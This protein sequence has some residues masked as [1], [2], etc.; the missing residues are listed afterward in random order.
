[1]SSCLE[2]TTHSL[3]HQFGGEPRRGV[4][5]KHSLHILLVELIADVIN[6]M[7]DSMVADP[8]DTRMEL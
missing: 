6:F 3:A 2:A 7:W 4:S 1:M 8:S 5:G